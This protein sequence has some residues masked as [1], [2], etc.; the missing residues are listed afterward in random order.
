MEGWGHCR[1]LIDSI[2][3]LRPTLRWVPTLSCPEFLPESAWVKCRERP[4]PS[5]VW[6]EPGLATRAEGGSHGDPIVIGGK[7][8]GHSF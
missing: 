1:V 5:T 6:R 7:G 3:I 4:L 8:A 2:S